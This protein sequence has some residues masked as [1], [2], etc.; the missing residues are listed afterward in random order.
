MLLAAAQ[1]WQGNC[2]IQIFQ[3]RSYT[4]DWTS[5]NAD[6]CQLLDFLLGTNSGS[7]RQWRY[8]K[9]IFRL[10]KKIT[11]SQS[12]QKHSQHGVRPRPE[13]QK[14]VSQF[15]AHTLALTSDRTFPWLHHSVYFC[16]TTLTRPSLPVLCWGHPQ[17]PQQQG[18]IT[19]QLSSNRLAPL[20]GAGN[21][22]VFN[23]FRRSKA[24]VLYVVPPFVVAWLAMK[25]A[26]ER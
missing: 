12:G 21:A 6:R 14:R 24:Q 20:G 11:R 25:W 2:P 1:P 4:A 17:L 23:T 26:E 5:A 22:A 18:I 7:G 13:G 10:S 9:K 19:Y 8:K 16:N 15:V 3:A